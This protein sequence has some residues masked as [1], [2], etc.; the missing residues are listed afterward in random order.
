MAKLVENNKIN[1]VVL[2]DVMIYDLTNFQRD[3]AEVTD[4]FIKDYEDLFDKHPKI[5]E[6][7]LEYLEESNLINY[8]DI[9]LKEYNANM[10]YYDFFNLHRELGDEFSEKINK[11]EIEE[12]I[13]LLD[14]LQDEYGGKYT[15]HGF[16]E[17]RLA[18]HTPNV[19]K[20]K[21]GDMI[22]LNVRIVRQDLTANKFGSSNVMTNY[23]EL[24]V[25]GEPQREASYKIDDKLESI[26]TMILQKILKAYKEG[27]SYLDQ[28]FIEDRDALKD[29]YESYVEDYTEFFDDEDVSE[30][31]D[32]IW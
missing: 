14:F 15:Q 31:E 4:K 2:N 26:N 29:V 17:L 19:L 23:F 7:F 28:F 25:V 9:T 27:K 1:S 32:L 18:D 6:E 13:E 5:Y 22:L 30:L 3:I 20:N 8:T 11:L 12:D 24:D 10:F 16:I 21:L